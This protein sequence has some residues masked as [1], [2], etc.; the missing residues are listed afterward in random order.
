MLHHWVKETITLLPP[1]VQAAIEIDVDPVD[2]C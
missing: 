2:L 1:S